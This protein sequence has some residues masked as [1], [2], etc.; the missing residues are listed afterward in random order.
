MTK[1]GN[2]LQNALKGS[3]AI[4]NVKLVS[5]GVKYFMSHFHICCRWQTL[6]SRAHTN[7]QSTN[8]SRPGSRG[9]YRTGDHPGR[10]EVELIAD[11]CPL[12]SAVQGAQRY[13]LFEKLQDVNDQGKAFSGFVLGMEWATSFEELL[14]RLTE[15]CEPIDCPSTY[16]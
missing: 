14:K 5:Q 15:L 2:L 4:K 3:I 11:C 12:S 16:K 7:Q 9:I 10:T 6:T 13:N 1:A 8:H